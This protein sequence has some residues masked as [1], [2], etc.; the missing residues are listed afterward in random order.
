MIVSNFSN[1]MFLPKF[2]FLF[3]FFLKDNEDYYLLKVNGLLCS[4]CKIMELS[5]KNKSVVY[6]FKN[7]L[8]SSSDDESLLSLEND[9]SGIQ[10]LETVQDEKIETKKLFDVF[11]KFKDKLK[12]QNGS[13]I[14]ILSALFLSLG[15]VFYKKATS[16]TG[17]DNSIFRYVIQLITM[18]CILLYKKIP[19]LGPKD[20][21]K[22]LFQRSF[23]GIF[24][25]VF[26]NFAIKYID[27]S[28][29]LALSHTN[30]IIT[31]IM[32][33]IFLKEKL[34]L[35]HFFAAILTLTGILLITKPTFL[36]KKVNDNVNETNSSNGM[37]Y[38]SVRD[39][40][41]HGV[42][43]RL[44]GIAFAIIGA[45]GSAA[46]HVIVR[47]LSMNKV[48]FAVTT[49][50]GTFLGLPA[51]IVTSVLLIVTGLFH[52]DPIC[53]LKYLPYDIMYGL[54][55]GAFAVLAHVTFNISLQYEDATKVA[56]LRTI[57][58]LFSFLLQFLILGINADYISALGA[59]AILLGTFV[60]L[61][62]KFIK[63][64]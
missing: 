58:V 47:K 35:Q 60:I 29:N 33:R 10:S 39:Y 32:A 17:S 30:I 52:N 1:R 55:G 61:F 24:A 11:L 53:E 12:A 20:Q 64:K 9:C 42:Y 7:R 6:G 51:S 49:L 4:D 46:I 26:T 40:S 23:F 54:I 62:F 22:L 50:Y 16:M 41:T 45:F 3:F 25:V 27:P 57:D 28:D 8:Y 13:L 43:D 31:A 59:V 2:L 63:K 48:Y 5:K 37:C 38:I 19:L 56:I 14:A 18:T 21:R 36:F 34:G 15:G 44:I